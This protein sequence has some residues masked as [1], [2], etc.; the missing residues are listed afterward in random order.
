MKSYALATLAA[1]MMDPIFF[2]SLA[3][4]RL[5]LSYTVFERG[6]NSQQATSSTGTQNVA[7]GTVLISFLSRAEDDMLAKNLLL[8]SRC[9]SEL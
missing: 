9:C 5:T 8:E 1:F 6:C 3:W 4:M 2:S 7:I